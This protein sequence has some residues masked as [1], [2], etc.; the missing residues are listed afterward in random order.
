MTF[1]KNFL[2]R[3]AAKLDVQQI[4]DIISVE[5]YRTMGV[6]RLEKIV[7]S[8]HSVACL[9]PIMQQALPKPKE[10]TIG[11]PDTAIML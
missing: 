4:S 7:F 9:L 5:D 11:G 3:V 1:G 6:A 8:H 2:P 10:P